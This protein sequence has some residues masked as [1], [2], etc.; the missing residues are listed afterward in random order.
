MAS[1]KVL[2]NTKNSLAIE[3][4]LEKNKTHDIDNI[5]KINT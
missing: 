2:N 3:V 5:Y 1:R 4:F